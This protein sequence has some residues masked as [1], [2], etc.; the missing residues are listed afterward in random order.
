M[1]KHTKVGPSWGQYPHPVAERRVSSRALF[2]TT[3]PSPSPLTC[4]VPPSIPSSAFA[5]PFALFAPA[6]PLTV[7]RTRL[8]ALTSP[9]DGPKRNDQPKGRK[10]W[11]GTWSTCRR[12]H[13][14]FRTPPNSGEMSQGK[15]GPVCFTIGTRL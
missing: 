3:D 12:I 4:S 6:S 11:G 14:E 5:L 9:F 7:A 2:W 10:G 15:K 8:R 13:T 1:R